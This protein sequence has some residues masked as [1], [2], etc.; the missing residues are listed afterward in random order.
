MRSEWVVLPWDESLKYAHRILGGKDCESERL[1][2]FAKVEIWYK[3]N[4]EIDPDLTYDSAYCRKNGLGKYAKQGKEDLD[5]EAKKARGKEK[6][7]KSGCGICCLCR[8]IGKIL[9][10]CLNNV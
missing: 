9:C 1:N 8:C 6:E 4:G 7:K 5:N 3:D 2:E 10:C